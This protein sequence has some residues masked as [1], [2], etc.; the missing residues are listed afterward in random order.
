MK[1]HH[2]SSSKSF[3]NISKTIYS[4]KNSRSVYKLNQTCDNAVI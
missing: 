3:K 1:T 2:T 4:M